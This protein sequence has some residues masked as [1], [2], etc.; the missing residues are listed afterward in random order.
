MQPKK[1]LFLCTANSCRSQMAEG[2]A[3]ELAPQGLP[4]YSAGTQ[5]KGV[6]PLAIKV[7][8]EVG[9]DISDQTSK[10]IE[11]VSLE[12]VDLVVT[13]CGEAAETCPT[14]PKKAEFLHWPIPDPALAR[15]DEKTVLQSFRQARD[16]IRAR[17]EQLFSPSTL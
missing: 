8:Q 3:R 1:I 10:G 11:K 13:L 7:M 5:P 2:F 9:I 14:L 15:G 6:H 4:I 17:V 16:E 12:K